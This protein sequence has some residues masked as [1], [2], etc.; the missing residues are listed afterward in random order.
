MDPRGNFR[1]YV[2]ACVDITELLKKEQQ[3]CVNSKNASRWRQKPRSTVCG[4]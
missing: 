2:G 4:N 1:G 3:R